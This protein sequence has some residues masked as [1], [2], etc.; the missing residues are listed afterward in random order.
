MGI[1][2]RS[3]NGTGKEKGV[4][5]MIKIK[6]EGQI[7]ALMKNNEVIAFESREEYDEWVKTME[8]K[9]INSLYADGKVFFESIQNGKELMAHMQTFDTHDL[10]DWGVNTD[11]IRG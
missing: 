7:I 9:K 4:D 3:Q 5:G 1:S 6:A 2:R 11:L 10:E 8:T